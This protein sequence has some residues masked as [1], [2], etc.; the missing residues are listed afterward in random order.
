MFAT[1]LAVAAALAL[2]VLFV[3]PL[4]VANAL[5]NLLLASLAFAAVVLGF[6]RLRLHSRSSEQ[7]RPAPGLASGPAQA[8]TDSD[9]VLV[10]DLVG[11][12]DRGNRRAPGPGQ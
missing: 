1:R 10:G 3:G 5:L 4:L 2:F 11:G 12:D 7:A 9:D 8:L 6:R